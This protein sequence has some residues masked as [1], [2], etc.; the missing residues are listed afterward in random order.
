[1][2][3]WRQRRLNMI[4]TVS[5]F[6]C[7]VENYS[8][9]R[10]DFAPDAIE[11]IFAAAKI[12]NQAAVADIGAGTG[13]LSQH[14]LNRV[15][16]V[17]A[18]EP[19]PEMRRIAEKLLN[20]SPAFFSINGYANATTLPDHSVDLIV[21]GRAI[22]WFDPPSTK[23]EFLRILK[24][25]GWLAVLQ[26][27]CTDTTLLQAIKSIRTQENGWNVKGDKSKQ[28][29]EP[30]SFY[31]GH[32]NFWVQQFPATKLERWP[33]FLGRLSSISSAPDKTHPRYPNYKRAAK[34]IFDQFS[35]NGL[36]TVQIATELNLG[37]MSRT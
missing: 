33:E 26:T 28:N 3:N 37:Q 5:R 13:M 7:K 36:L 14:F 31:Y 10:W 19:N 32:D 17:L 15:E 9:Y 12:S 8:K 34:K 6:S 23:A 1:M 2:I 25:N 35:D 18:V 11:F 27:P 4:D 21:V 22:H 29:I 24:P 30:L 20:N 16:K